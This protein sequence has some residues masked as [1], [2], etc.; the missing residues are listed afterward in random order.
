[1]CPGADPERRPGRQAHYWTAARQR[2]LTVAMSQ[3]RDCALPVATML[4]GEEAS[5]K[6]R[7]VIGLAACALMLTMA[8][9]AAAS[10]RHAGVRHRPYTHR[11]G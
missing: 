10:H 7:L 11:W 1:L 4:A 3:P 5:M 2:T 6:M 8:A 9:P